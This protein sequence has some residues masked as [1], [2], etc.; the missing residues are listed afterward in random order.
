LDLHFNCFLQHYKLFSNQQSSDGVMDL[1]DDHEE[2]NQSKEE[3]RNK[4]RSCSSGFTSGASSCVWHKLR[5]GCNGIGN[6]IAVCNN[7][8]SAVDFGIDDDSV[9]HAALVVIG[10]SKDVHKDVSGIKVGQSSYPE[11]EFLRCQ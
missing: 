8:L 9:S 10:S 4:R 5:V 1:E 3:E 11:S 7:I 6:C 2:G